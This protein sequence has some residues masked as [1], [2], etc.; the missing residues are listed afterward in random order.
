[1]SPEESEPVRL[2]DICETH[3]AAAT[4]NGYDVCSAWCEAVARKKEPP[5]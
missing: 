3:E 4:A 2:C 1:M 5:Q